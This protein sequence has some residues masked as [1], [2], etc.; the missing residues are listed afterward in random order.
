M[1]KGKQKADLNSIKVDRTTLSTSHTNITEALLS[2][3]TPQGLDDSIHSPTKSSWAEEVNAMHVDK[4][5]LSFD[6]NN[7]SQTLEEKLTV[8][9]HL[10][11]DNIPNTNQTVLSS[12]NK[13]NLPEEETFIKIPKVTHF[14]ATLSNVKIEGDTN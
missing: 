9:I 14:F 7:T 11:N 2:K 1:S 3:T 5:S 12:T 13:E 8:A 6:K 4:T 10:H